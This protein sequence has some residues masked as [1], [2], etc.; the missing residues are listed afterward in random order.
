MW[1]ELSL[2][3]RPAHRLAR[4]YATLAA[5]LLA[6]CGVLVVGP[7]FAVIDQE[8]R[9]SV[10][11]TVDGSYS[12]LSGDSFSPKSGQCV[13]YSVNTSDWTNHRMVQSGLVRCNDKVLDAPDCPG[14]TSFVETEVGN[15]YHCV[16]GYTITNDTQY[17]ATTYRTSSSGS[18]VHG[19]VNGASAS[20]GGISVGDDVR[21]YAWGEA[22]GSSSTCPAPSRG[23]FTLWK[24]YDTSA[25]WT[26]VTSSSKHHFNSMPSTCWTS[27]S[28]VS[29]GEFDVD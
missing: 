10:S 9:V 20:L 7:A 8:G 16:A 24:K 18:T 27:I 17:D 23:V 2:A 12:R 29:S 1:N 26:Y 28:A 5:V 19:H 21:A 11:H 22:T 13:I 3:G 14:G 25:G 15:T 6:A 4:S